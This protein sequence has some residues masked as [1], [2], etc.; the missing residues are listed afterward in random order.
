MINIILPKFNGTVS[1]N[2]FC[3]P[4]TFCFCQKPTKASTFIGAVVEPLRSFISQHGV[5]LRDAVQDR[6]SCDVMSS[7]CQQYVHTLLL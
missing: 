5:V 2:F 7:V 3:I 6:I 1:I 4:C